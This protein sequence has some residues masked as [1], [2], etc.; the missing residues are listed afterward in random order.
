[1]IPKNID[2]TIANPSFRQL[3]GSNRGSGVIK[4]LAPIGKKD[5]AC[6]LQLSKSSFRGYSN[7]LV[8]PKYEIS[9]RASVIFFNKILVAHF[10]PQTDAFSFLIPF[11]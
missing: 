2:L 3:I 10:E 6:P 7:N 8:V 1:V 11:F 5:G 4:L 9:S